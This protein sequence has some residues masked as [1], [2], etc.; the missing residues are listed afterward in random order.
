MPALLKT[1]SA[2]VDSMGCRSSAFCLS[3]PFVNAIDQVEFRI[4]DALVVGA[5]VS[6]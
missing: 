2:S 6:P 4:G 5:L 3:A 1:R